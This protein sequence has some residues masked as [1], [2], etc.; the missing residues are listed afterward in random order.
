MEQE[1]V[2]DFLKRLAD[3]ISI[4]FGN[5]CE[6]VIRDMNNSE[7]AIVYVKNDHIT[8]KDIDNELSIFGLDEKDAFTAGNDLVNSK[9]ITKNKR[10][11]KTS[12]FHI[13]EEDYHYTFVINYDYTHLSIAQSILNDFTQVG[14]DRGLNLEEDNSVAQ[15]LE[16]LYEEAIAYI[17]KPVPVMKKEE[18]VKMVR[19]LNEKGAFSIHKGI[20]TISEKMNLSRYTIYNYLKEIKEVNN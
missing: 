4:M 5:Q 10:M 7:S 17:G 3:G 12:S 2:L 6:V 9:G 18:R 11:I 16:D 8:D 19:Y 13:K 20:P 14:E 15:M 1:N